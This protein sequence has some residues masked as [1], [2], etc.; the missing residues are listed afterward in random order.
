MNSSRNEFD[1]RPV[2]SAPRLTE[3]FSADMGRG[4]APAGVPIQKRNQ[5]ACRPR[6]RH[7]RLH[8]FLVGD[9]PALELPIFLVSPILCTRHPA[10]W[11]RIAGLPLDTDIE[12]RNTKAVQFRR[13]PANDPQSAV[14]WRRNGAAQ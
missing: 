5:G 7:S 1:F 4:V 2:G 11:N 12:G 10:D 13:T 3:R 6:S 14:G 9:I 8:Y